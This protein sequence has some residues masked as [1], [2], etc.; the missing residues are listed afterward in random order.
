MPNVKATISPGYRWRLVLITLL[1]LGF[2]A[3]CIYD[4]QVAYPRTKE[5]GLAY[6][7]IK[8]ENPDDYPEVWKAHATENGWPT[9]STKIKIKSE[10]DYD[11]D[12]RTQL[13]MALITMP[14]GLFFLYKLIT[15]SLRWVEMDQQGVTASGGHVAPWDSLKSLDETRWKTKGIAKLHYRAAAGGERVILL[16]DFKSEREPIKAI[17]T[18]AQRVLHPE[19]VIDETVNETSD[20]TAAT[21]V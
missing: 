8:A 11:S 17:V 4:W 19:A 15:E 3:Y 21:T 14:I 6:Q 12:I 9:S 16:D 10:A 20:E 18:E 1:M 5:I 2:G 13:I 7:Q